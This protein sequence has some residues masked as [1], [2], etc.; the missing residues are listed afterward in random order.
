MNLASCTRPRQG[1]DLEL[2]VE[3]STFGSGIEL[4]KGYV[5]PHLGT[6]L[7]EERHRN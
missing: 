7:V 5:C 6:Q 4:R 1:K 3:E 2:Q